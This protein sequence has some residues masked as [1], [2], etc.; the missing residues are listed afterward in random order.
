MVDKKKNEKENGHLGEQSLDNGE[1]EIKAPSLASIVNPGTGK[2]AEVSPET[3][4]ERY[5]C[6]C[7]TCEIKALRKEINYIYKNINAMHKKID[8][9]LS[10]VRKKIRIFEGKTA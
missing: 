8:T 7:G 10:L 3:K 5:S 9:I 2:T 1:Y 6:N 4:Q